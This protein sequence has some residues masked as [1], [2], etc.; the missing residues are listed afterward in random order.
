MRRHRLLRGWGLAE[1]RPARIVEPMRPGVTRSDREIARRRAT[2]LWL[3][4]GPDGLRRN[5]TG[6]ASDTAV[7]RH[8]ARRVPVRPRI[9]VRAAVSVE[10]D[11][12]RSLGR[13][14]R[15]RIALDERLRAV[16]EVIPFEPEPSVAPRSSTRIGGV[17]TRVSGCQSTLQQPFRRPAQTERATFLRGAHNR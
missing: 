5:P 14:H 12:T 17:I 10:E 16:V 2:A 11:A 13:R 15:A 6:R 9:E 8:R 3:V 1:R 4:G 7:A